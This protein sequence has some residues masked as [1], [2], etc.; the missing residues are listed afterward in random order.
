MQAIGKDTPAM[1]VANHEIKFMGKHLRPPHRVLKAYQHP[2]TL[3]IESSNVCSG[4]TCA[5]GSSH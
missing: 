1:I 2:P 4:A 3:S 5:G